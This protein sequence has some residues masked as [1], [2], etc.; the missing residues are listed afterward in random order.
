ME[1][2]KS[3][4]SNIIKQ[5]NQRFSKNEFKILN[6]FYQKNTKKNTL[7]RVWTSLSGDHDYTIGFKA[8]NKESFVTVGYFENDL[9]QV[10]LT[11]IY[12]KY[13]RKWKINII[14]IGTLRIM[15]K[16]AF[17]WYE[18]AKS[19]YEKGYLIDAANDLSL[20]NQLLKPANEYWNYQNA[21]EITKY[22]DIV[23]AKI[24]GQFTF[25]LTV[26]YVKTKPQIF[27]IYPQE[28]NEGYFPMILYTTKNSM[29]D[30][31][32][33]SKECDEL[34]KKIGDLFKGIDKNNKMI[35]YRAYRS[36]PNDTTEVENYGFIRRNN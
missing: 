26:E 29:S 7:T 18:I 32:K 19:D 17:D 28:I 33:L 16:D 27:Q 3:N 34:H 24:Y 23:K 21:K 4:L 2:S 9:N 10:C 1:K 8:L 30:T 5:G 11:L 6:E 35:F 14:S 25:P 20:A 22:R 13:G 31:I 12:G 15:N 36:I